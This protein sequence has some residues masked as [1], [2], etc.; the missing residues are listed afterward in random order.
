[1]RSSQPNREGDSPHPGA[2]VAKGWGG[3]SIWPRTTRGSRHQ[4]I[5]SAGARTAGVPIADAGGLFEGVGDRR[6]RSKVRRGGLAVFRSRPESTAS[7]REVDR[8]NADLTGAASDLTEATPVLHSWATPRAARSNVPVCAHGLRALREAQP[9]RRRGRGSSA[10]TSPAEQVDRRFQLDD[11]RATW[12][13]RS[14]VRVRRSERR[15][16]A[17]RATGAPV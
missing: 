16:R 4:R 8:I 15:T 5:R 9:E 6:G 12:P 13:T 14:A 1:M 17:R 7:G 10:W 2:W 3:R 11:E